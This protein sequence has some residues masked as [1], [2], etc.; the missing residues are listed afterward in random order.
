MM[1]MMFECFA[2]DPYLR[3]G[4]QG[5]LRLTFLSSAADFFVPYSDSTRNSGLSCA[6]LFLKPLGLCSCSMRCRTTN[7]LPGLQRKGSDKESNKHSCS[8][9]T[10][11]PN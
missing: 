8:C 11:M 2:H 10:P 6:R 4:R 7:E 5:L 9:Q 1:L 3:E